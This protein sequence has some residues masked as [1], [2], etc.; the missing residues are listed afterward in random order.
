M[1]FAKPILKKSILLFIFIIPFISYSFASNKLSIFT[2]NQIKPEI[3]FIAHNMP[4]DFIYTDGVYNNGEGKCKFEQNYDEPIEWDNFT[5]DFDFFTN[6]KREQWPIMMGTATRSIG[7]LLNKN[8]TIEITAN[9]QKQTYQTQGRYETNRWYHVKIVKFNNNTEIYLNETKIGEFQIQIDED[10][11]NNSQNNISS[12]NYSNGIAFDG[13]LRNIIYIKNGNLEFSEK[14]HK[15][16]ASKYNDENLVFSKTENVFQ[17]TN[18]YKLLNLNWKSFKVQFDYIHTDDENKLIIGDKWKIIDFHTIND[19]ASISINNNRISYL[20]ALQL[21]PEHKYKIEIIINNDLLQMSI[22]DNVILTTRFDYYNEKILE[23]ENE[24]FVISKKEKPSNIFKSLTV[25]N[26][27][28]PKKITNPSLTFQKNNSSIDTIN[29]GVLEALFIPPFELNIK[30]IDPNNEFAF[31]KSISGFNTDSFEMDFDFLTNNKQEQDL[32]ALGVYT[33]Y[34]EI[35][36]SIVD[37]HLIFKTNNKKSIIKPFNS[38]TIKKNWNN[39]KIT[40]ENGFLKIYL[41]NIKTHEIKFKFQ[42]QFYK[43]KLLSIRNTFVGQFKNLY[44]YESVK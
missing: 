14:I 16:Y 17:K 39:C 25:A 15:K 2:I 12:V 27:V 38:N 4:Y 1:S 29:E 30:E 26:N 5:L 7:F 44:I 41:N 6:K 10:A 40:Y 18:E 33:K 23:T 32:I 35:D 21:V 34:S 20:S 13:G 37:N 31:T 19:T 8:M 42:E 36:L 3:G 9:N 11:K 28:I 43:S 22:D 24:I